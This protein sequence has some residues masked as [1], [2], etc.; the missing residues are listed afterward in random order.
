MMAIRGR[1][2]HDGIENTSTNGPLARL[3]RRSV[4]RISRVR[5]SLAA[6][7][8]RNPSPASELTAASLG[9]EFVTDRKPAAALPAT[10]R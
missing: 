9:A 5:R 8:N 10:P 6:R 7:G 2:A 3:P 4:R 1:P